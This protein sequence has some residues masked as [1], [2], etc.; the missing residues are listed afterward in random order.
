MPKVTASGSYRTLSERL[1]A[2]AAAGG[3]QPGEWAAVTLPSYMTDLFAMDPADY[4][5]AGA[6]LDSNE[7]VY[8]RGGLF[9]NVDDAAS[10]FSWAGSATDS[11]GS[12]LVATLPEVF[13]PQKIRHVS[14]AVALISGSDAT[15]MLSSLAVHPDGAV[16]LGLGSKSPDGSTSIQSLVAGTPGHL[17]SVGFVGIYHPE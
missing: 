8:L 12:V 16:V 10:S 15:Y 7:A 5:P 1:A 9:M 11:P 13:Q 3:Y 4:D 17:M 2:E 14:S 6:R